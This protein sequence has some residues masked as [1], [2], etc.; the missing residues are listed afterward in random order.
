MSMLSLMDSVN[1]LML[2]L[3]LAN[4]VV[5]GG[6]VIVRSSQEE[7]FSDALADVIYPRDHSR[8]QPSVGRA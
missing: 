4:F 1:R 8:L 6:A 2:P 3:I 5:M 7:H